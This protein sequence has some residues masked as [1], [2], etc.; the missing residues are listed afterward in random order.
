MEFRQIQVLG[1]ERVCGIDR[2]DPTDP[3]DRAYGC[4]KFLYNRIDLSARTA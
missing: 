2:T 3:T 4:A 1:G